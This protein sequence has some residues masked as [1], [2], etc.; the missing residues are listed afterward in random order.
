MKK[1]EQGKEIHS[2]TVELWMSVT[3]TF[4]TEKKD[5]PYTFF[6]RGNSM[7]PLIRSGRD[8]VTVCRCDV[9]KLKCGDIVLFREHAYDLDYVLHRIYRIRG[10]RMQT[11][12]DGNLKLDPWTDKKQTCGKVV[13]IQ[14][15]KLTIA[16]QK[17]FWRWMALIWMLGYPYREVPIRVFHKLG[18]W[19]NRWK[20]K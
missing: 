17:A 6:V 15:G 9:E 5:I 1:Q 14:R 2:A 3:E 11:L 7:Y 19:K 8:S 20:K 4:A 13:K 12:G 10:E 16:P 18:D